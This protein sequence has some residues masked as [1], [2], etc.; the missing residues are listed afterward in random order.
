[1]SRSNQTDIANPC[2]RWMEWNGEKGVFKFYDKDVKQNIEIEPSQ[3]FTFLL[4]DQMAC[5]KGWNDASESGIYSNEVRD[6]TK[7]PLVVKAFKGGLIASGFYKEIKDKVSAN[8]GHFTGSIYVAIKIDGELKIGNLQLKGAA[9]NTWIEFRNKN[10]K[11]LYSKAIT[12]KTVQEG[13]KG[14]VVF[15]TPVFSLIPVSQETDN[16][17]K[18]LDLDLQNYFKVYFS[19]TTSDQSQ[20]ERQPQLV[21]DEMPGPI[22]YPSLDDADP[23]PF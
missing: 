4:L 13:Q 16:I 22:E 11:D 5:V 2:A 14:R 21:A 10:R 23:L 7:E 6:L 3:E 20:P 15:K 1:M 17:A 19:R 8:G 18:S 12:V 9:L